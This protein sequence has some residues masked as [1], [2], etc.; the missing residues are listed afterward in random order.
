MWICFNLEITSAVLVAQLLIVDRTTLCSAYYF[1]IEKIAYVLSLVHWSLVTSEM[2]IFL[3]SG[4]VSVDTE[5][6]S[7]GVSCCRI[8]SRFKAVLICSVGNEI[9]SGT[10]RL[11]SYYLHFNIITVIRLLLP[12][13]L[14]IE[15]YPKILYSGDSCIC[16]VSLNT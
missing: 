14:P 12:L 15:T 3:S 2:F 16:L 9:R 1:N 10:S 4:V 5:I 7:S 13:Q 11:H 6:M 8:F